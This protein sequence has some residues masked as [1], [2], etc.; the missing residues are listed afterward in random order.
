MRVKNITTCQFCD[1][2][3]GIKCY[4]IYICKVLDEKCKCWAEMRVKNI[5]TCQFCDVL[6]GIECYII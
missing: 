6:E 3:E 2:L 4:I 1:V 5:I